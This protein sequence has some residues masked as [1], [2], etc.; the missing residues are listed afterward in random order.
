[1]EQDVKM[2]RVM[3]YLFSGL[4]GIF[5]TIVFLVRFIAY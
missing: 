4:F 1:M 2:K 5:L 3:T